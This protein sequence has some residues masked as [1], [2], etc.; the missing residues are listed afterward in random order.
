[1]FVFATSPLCAQSL[2]EYT[3]LSLLIC[4]LGCLC[5]S[6]VFIS[7]FRMI[8]QNSK[9]NRQQSYYVHDCSFQQFISYFLWLHLQWI[10]GFCFILINFHSFD[11]LFPGSAKVGQSVPQERLA[12]SRSRRREDRLQVNSLQQGATK[13]IGSCMQSQNFIHCKNLIIIIFHF[14][15]QLIEFQTVN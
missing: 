1:M 13:R 9:T 14:F 4:G 7:K 3:D 5:P 8:K 11:F 6:D 2:Q 15:S 12:W 10:K